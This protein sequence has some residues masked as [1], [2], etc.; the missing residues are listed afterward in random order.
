MK[1]LPASDALTTTNYLNLPPRPKM[2]DQAGLKQVTNI[3]NRFLPLF[4]D[5]RAQ[6]HQTRRKL[7][8]SVR[9]RM[10]NPDILFLLGQSLELALFVIGGPNVKKGWIGLDPTDETEKALKDAIKEFCAERQ[11]LMFEVEDEARPLW[12][13]FEASNAARDLGYGE[14]ALKDLEG[15][16]G[17]YRDWVNASQKNLGVALGYPT[18]GDSHPAL[19]GLGTHARMTVHYNFRLAPGF[20]TEFASKSGFADP[21]QGQDGE[22]EMLD[23]PFVVNFAC[24]EENLRD[25]IGEVYGNYAEVARFAKENGVGVTELYIENSGVV[26]AWTAKGASGEEKK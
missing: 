22:G 15:L 24:I 6:P 2:T 17:K 21:N 13:L 25:K 16:K 1:R 26:D 5:P 20:Q 3:I 14:H 7:I 23:V 12:G 19:L 11:I 8:Q 9:K 18:A 4:Q 10:D